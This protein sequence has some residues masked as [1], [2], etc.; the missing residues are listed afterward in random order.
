MGSTPEEIQAALKLDPILYWQTRIQSEGPQHQVILSQPFYLGTYEVTQKE[1]LAIMGTNPSY[2]SSTGDGK[3]AVANLDTANHPVES[4]SWSDATQFCINLCQKQSLKPHYFRAGDTMT[5]LKGN[6]YR[7]PTEA[8]WEF[9]CRAGSTTPFWFSNDFP[10]LAQIGWTTENSGDRTHAV[11]E[12]KEN[13]WGLFDVHGNALEWVE[14]YWEP[15]FYQQFANQV[16]VDPVCL[17]SFNSERIIRGGPWNATATHS[18]S[19][20]RH[21]T[22]GVPRDTRVGFRVALS[23]EAVREAQKK[24]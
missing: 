15:T 22:N 4:V 1:Y 23:V 18:R 24:D 17:T 6:G 11:G 9:A 16:S 10:S 21:A 2:F 14:D 12:L 7:L 13:P 20:H 5:R 19:S 8:E 3:E